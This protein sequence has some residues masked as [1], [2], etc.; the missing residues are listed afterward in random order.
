M[1]K[2]K[3]TR[4]YILEKACETGKDDGLAKLNVRMVANAVGC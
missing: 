1:S 4:E 2:I 3:F